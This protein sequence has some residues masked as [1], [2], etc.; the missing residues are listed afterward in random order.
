VIHTLKTFA[1][2]VLRDIAYPI[3]DG[4]VGTVRLGLIEES[5]RKDLNEASR[6]LILMVLTFL[7]IGLIGAFFFSYMITL[8]IKSIATRAQNI[9]L[10]DIENQDFEVHKLRFRTIFGIYFKDELDILT[11]KFNEMMNRLKGNKKELDESRNSVIQA[12]KLA[13]IGTLTAGISH[14][15]NNP[16][17]GIKNCIKRIEKDPNNTDQNLKYFE[18]IKDA[19][20][21][22]ESVVKP[23]LDYSRTKE[24]KLTDFSPC[25]VIQKTLELIDYKIKKHQ[26]EIV[27]NCD[28]KLLLRSN[29]NLF[30]QVTFNLLLNAIDAIEEKKKILPN[31]VGIL[32][33]DIHKEGHDTLIRIGDNGSGIKKSFQHKIFDPFFS[34]KEVGKGTGLGLYV[35]YKI[36]QDLGGKL[37]FETKELEGTTFIIKLADQIEAEEE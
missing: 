13:S 11:S 23:L 12:E 36:I 14:E 4:K 33:L 34:S 10:K 19:T 6:S 15:I 26:I 37:S 21:R 25:T 17:T 3:L 24:I 2:E 28:E 30:E 29:S 1:H 27:K 18:L 8:P 32:T 9:N 7:V 20:D 35:S 22:I 16:L 31:H 5:I